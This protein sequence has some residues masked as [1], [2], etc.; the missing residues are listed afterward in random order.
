MFAAV[1][2]PGNS[3]DA[4]LVELNSGATTSFSYEV[5]VVARGRA[6]SSGDLVVKI[7]NG[8]GE[9]IGVEWQRANL[10]V[11]SCQQEAWFSD[12]TNRWTGFDADG[13]RRAVE[14]RLASP[15]GT[16]PSLPQRDFY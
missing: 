2:S 5:H 15:S 4:V 3:L 10:L 9:Q 6:S 12:F 16:S 1:P 7:W 8:C 13:S 14:I 11:V